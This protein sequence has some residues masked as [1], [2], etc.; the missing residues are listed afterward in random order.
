MGARRRAHCRGRPRKRWRDDLDVFMRDWPEK[1][2]QR[3]EGKDMGEISAQH[4]DKI[5]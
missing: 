5:G 2:I 1:A 4:W 3:K